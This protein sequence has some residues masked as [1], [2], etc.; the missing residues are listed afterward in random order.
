MKKRIR[1]L[2]A[3][4]KLLLNAVY[5]RCAN[6]LRLNI[7]RRL[8]EEYKD[9][10]DDCLQN[11][12]LITVNNFDKFKKAP[13]KDGWL[14]KASTIA[15]LRYCTEEQHYHENELSF[16]NIETAVRQS[17]E[18]AIC[19]PYG[20]LRLIRLIRRHLSPKNGD[21]FETVLTLNLSFAELARE[22]GITEAAVRAKWRRLLDEI[23]S[24]PDEIKD[25]F[26]FL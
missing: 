18:G 16:A 21:F 3:E 22:L 7:Y 1:R 15:V 14:Y 10:C 17:F 6:A 2:T 25:K 9:A 19:D 4:E 23:S 8:P 12:I 26:H 20:R 13:S 24:L 11:T 5:Q